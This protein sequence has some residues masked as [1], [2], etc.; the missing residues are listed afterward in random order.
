[1]NEESIVDSLTE[2]Q[3]EVLR[4]VHA[5]HYM[6]TDDDM[7]ENYERWLMNLTTDEIINIIGHVE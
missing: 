3:E 4:D 5:E 7:P 2:E 6:G 1:M